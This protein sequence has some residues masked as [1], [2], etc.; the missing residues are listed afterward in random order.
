MKKGMQESN[1]D[2]KLVLTLVF[3]LFPSSSHKMLI[4]HLCLSLPPVAPT[5]A[6]RPN[7]FE[8]KTSTFCITP[9]PRRCFTLYKHPAQFT[10]LDTLLRHVRTSPSTTRCASDLS[11]ARM[12]IVSLRSCA[13]HLSNSSCAVATLTLDDDRFGTV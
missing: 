12:L 9:P 3:R 2:T 6:N 7:H 1:T 8:H 13:F 11:H 5:A 4:S 10:V